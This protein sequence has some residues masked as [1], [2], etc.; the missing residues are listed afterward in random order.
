MKK[1]I[2]TARAGMHQA[3]AGDRLVKNQDM[4]L[5]AASQTPCRVSGAL[6]SGPGEAVKAETLLI[7][8]SYRQAPRAANSV[9]V[10]T[11]I[12]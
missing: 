5:A 3:K 9:R 10:K 4:P 11:Q 7:G 12:H 8:T 2:H 1:A 6:S